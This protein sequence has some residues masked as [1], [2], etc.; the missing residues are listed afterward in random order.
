M[1]SIDRLR[2]YA[3]SNCATENERAILRM[4]DAIER[5]VE[6][7]LKV[8][9]GQMWLRGYGECHAELM[10]GNEVIAADLEKAG[11]VK[12]PVDADGEVW[13]VGDFAVGEVNP[14]NPKAIESMIWY[15]PDSGWQLE[16]DTIIYPCPD[17]PRHHRAPT[18]EDVLREFA[19]RLDEIGSEDD[20]VGVEEQECRASIRRDIAAAYVEYAAKLRLAEGVE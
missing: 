18:V 4:A 9:D 8:K 1:E 5:E 6:D 10:E 13:H 3:H 14:N 20:C 7:E 17:R 19:E 12:L 15:G 2:E 11:W 16:T